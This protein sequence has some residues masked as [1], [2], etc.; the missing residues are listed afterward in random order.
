MRQLSLN[1]NRMVAIAYYQLKGNSKKK[2]ADE[3]SINH[4]LV[5][6]YDR[7]L[8]EMSFDEYNQYLRYLIGGLQEHL[9][10]TENQ[11]SNKEVEKIN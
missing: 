11:Q 9:K 2:V 8:R 3:L 1:M 7:S 4:T 6:Q 10:W 5:K